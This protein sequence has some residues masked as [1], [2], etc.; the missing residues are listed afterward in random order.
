MYEKHLAIISMVKNW[1]MSY[2]VKNVTRGPLSPFVFNTVI[3]DFAR[4]RRQ[5]KETKG[6]PTKWNSNFP[7][8]SYNMCSCLKD[9]NTPPNS[10]Y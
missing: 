3:H 9:S 1:G 8:F 7:F 2:E 6:V 10:L 5:E 4:G